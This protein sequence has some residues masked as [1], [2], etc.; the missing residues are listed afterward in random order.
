MQTEGHTRFEQCDKTTRSIS[1][2]MKKRRYRLTLKHLPEATTQTMFWTFPTAI[3]ISVVFRRTLIER[4]LLTTVSNSMASLDAFNQVNLFT[5]SH[6]RILAEN[7]FSVRPTQVFELDLSNPVR[8]QRKEAGCEFVDER[9]TPRD[10]VVGF[11][12]PGY[13][14]TKGIQLGPESSFSFNLRTR[15][16]NAMLLYQA[17][18][19]KDRRLRVRDAE[20]DP[21]FIVFYL[22]NGRLIAQLGTDSQQR[23]KQPSL[24]SE[25]AYNDG[26]LHSVFL[27]RD[28]S[29]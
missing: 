7:I 5:S 3:T 4:H 1:R 11:S 25:H 12:R 14:L 28:K 16:P 26:Q 13:L 9:L 15:N 10:R 18:N 17:G 21:T 8:S 24:T 2:L 23:S 19:L 22:F 20:E 6:L 27:A 29:R